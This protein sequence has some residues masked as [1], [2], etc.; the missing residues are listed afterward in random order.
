MEAAGAADEQNRVQSGLAVYIKFRFCVLQDEG[1]AL[2]ERK[3][4]ELLQA[5]ESRSLQQL[6]IN[7][8]SLFVVAV[9]DGRLSVD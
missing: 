2:F 3:T 6:F 1:S 7:R 9:C 5:A 8:A 4:K